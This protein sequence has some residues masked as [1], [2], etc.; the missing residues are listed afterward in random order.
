MDSNKI[1][2]I[3]KLFILIFFISLLLG[4]IVYVLYFYFKTNNLDSKN[5][6][7][8]FIAEKQNTDPIPYTF[9]IGLDGGV[10]KDR[11]RFNIISDGKIISGE[12][13]NSLSGEKIADIQSLKG[14]LITQS[15]EKL[16]VTIIVQ[17]VLKNEKENIYSEVINDNAV[18]KRRLELNMNNLPLNK[19][20][21]QTI[22]PK[23]TVWDILVDLKPLDPNDPENNLNTGYIRLMPMM[24]ENYYKELENFLKAGGNMGRPIIPLSFFFLE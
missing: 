6:G 24:D 11:L 9:D 21:L 3:V 16:N 13:T 22:F 14:H 20:A 2:R 15:G 8:D 12:L 4:L 7:E 19:D 18:K 23:N 1:H 10:N 17:A 5:L